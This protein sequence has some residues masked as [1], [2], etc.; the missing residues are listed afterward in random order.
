MG[1]TIV[2][3][4]LNNLKK[5]HTRLNAKALDSIVTSRF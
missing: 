5:M 4:L 2:S 1:A 3:K